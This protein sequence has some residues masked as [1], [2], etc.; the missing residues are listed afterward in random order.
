MLVV[1]LLLRTVVYPLLFVLR[2]TWLKMSYQEKLLDLRVKI[3]NLDSLLSVAQKLC[4][5]SGSFAYREMLSESRNVVESMKAPV[6]AVEPIADDLKQQ[7]ESVR[8]M[9]NVSTRTDFCSTQ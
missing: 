9:P 5:K 2:S 6:D 4:E 1:W 3:A 7:V 8:R